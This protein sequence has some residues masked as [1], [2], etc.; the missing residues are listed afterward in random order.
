MAMIG[1][2]LLS[3]CL[4]PKFLEP[5]EEARKIAT[6]YGMLRHF[7]TTARYN[8]CDQPLRLSQFQRNKDCAKISP[9]S[10]RAVG[11]LVIKSMVASKVRGISNPTLPDHQ[12][13][14]TP[15]MEP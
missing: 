8:R 4:L 13:P 1:K 11:L 6:L 7:L 14:S 9:D 5:V 10:A 2:L 15:N 12:A 3:P